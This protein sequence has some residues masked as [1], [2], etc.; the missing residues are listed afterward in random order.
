MA[1]NV[2]D[3]FTLPLKA[4]KFLQAAAREAPARLS[5]GSVRVVSAEG[6]SHGDFCVTARLPVTE[7]F[8]LHMGLV[9][10]PGGIV[11]DAR[12]PFELF[13]TPRLGGCELVTVRRI[14][15]ASFHSEAEFDFENQVIHTH[16]VSFSGRRTLP[17]KYDAMFRLTGDGPWKRETI[18]KDVA[19][20]M[21]L[22]ASA[23]AEPWFP[24]PPRTHV[25]LSDGAL[26]ATDGRVLA[27]NEQL[28]IQAN[29][30]VDHVPAVCLRIAER[31]AKSAGAVLDRMELFLYE[32]G[33]GACRM[34]FG[35]DEMVFHYDW[36][37]NTK[38]APWRSVTSRDWVTKFVANPGI[39]EEALNWLGKYPIAEGAAP[40]SVLMRKSKEGFAL[41][42]LGGTP[43]TTTFEAAA[44]QISAENFE[45][46][47]LGEEPLRKALRFARGNGFTARYLKGEPGSRR[48][49]LDFM[50][51]DSVVLM[52]NVPTPA[53]LEEAGEPAEPGIF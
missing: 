20:R 45:A 11:L 40:R 26:H 53:Q 6:G 35:A 46:C 19:S 43:G 9:T 33:C 4:A 41:T 8:T 12:M 1:K 36:S 50:A 39:A 10:G 27:W 3:E 49:Y 22:Y 31:Y 23:A 48:L 34:L 32:D 30:D 2:I 44:E 52:A 13:S 42:L 47:V 25:W 29:P 7:E 15:V 16:T 18:G 17:R 21:L 28:R 38:P 5:Q 14:G 37:Q 51:G 24:N